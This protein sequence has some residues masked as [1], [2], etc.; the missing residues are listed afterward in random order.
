MRESTVGANPILSAQTSL[1]NPLQINHTDDWEF[2]FDPHAKKA[3]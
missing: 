3:L 1:L 2:A